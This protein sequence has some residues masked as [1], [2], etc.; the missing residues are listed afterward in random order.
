MH[1]V[2]YGGLQ[3]SIF[4]SSKAPFTH[5][6][7][8]SRFG[9]ALNPLAATSQD[10][11]VRLSKTAPIYAQDT[12]IVAEVPPPDTLSSLVPTAT[13]SELAGNASIKPQD[14]FSSFQVQLRSL[15]R[16]TIINV[17]IILV[18]L[19][20]VAIQ[21]FSI[22]TGITRGWSTE[23]VAYR[24]PI[25]NWRSYNDIL[26]MAP[27]QTKAVTSATVYTIGDIIAQRTEGIEIGELD[28]GRIGRSLAAGLIGHGPLSHV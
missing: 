2:D 10:K 23:E 22:D 24:V 25:D 18:V 13:E 27:I 4:C 17:S 14:F 5:T 28:R 9:Q 20:A 3:R 11:N 19:V 26:N 1:C 6:H 21:V 7:L 8:G 12:E 15:D 16:D